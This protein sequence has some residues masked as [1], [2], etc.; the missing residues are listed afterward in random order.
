MAEIVK[1]AEAAVKTAGTKAKKPV[2]KGRR[3]EEA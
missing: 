3:D 2:K 1:T